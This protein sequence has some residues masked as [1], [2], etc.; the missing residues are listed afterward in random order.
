MKKYSVV[1]TIMLVVVMVFVL[2]GCNNNKSGSGT[3]TGAGD[4]GLATEEGAGAANNVIAGSEFVVAWIH[5]SM[6]YESAAQAR[7]AAVEYIERHEIEWTFEE[8]DCEGD[9]AKVTSAIEDAVAKGVNAIM[10]DFCDLHAATNAIEL[11]NQSGI[12]VFSVD[13]GYYVPGIVADVTTNNA[14]GAS[15]VGMFMINQLGG[16]GKVCLVDTKNHS[17]VRMRVD[18]FRSI[19]GQHAGMEILND[20]NVDPLRI[21]ESVQDNM[22]ALVTRYGLDGID[23]VL[24]GWDEA[25]MAVANVIRSAGGSRSDIIVSGYDGH[26]DVVVDDMADPTYPVIATIAQNFPAYGT[27][28]IDLIQ[29]VVLNG[30]DELEAIGGLRTIYVRSSLVT[31]NNVDSVPERPASTA[32]TP[33]NDY[34]DYSNVTG[35]KYSWQ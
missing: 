6:G 28:P 20:F 21:M 34:G 33:D 7:A 32:M 15:R 30:E 35:Y 2:M 4:A 26:R 27:I 10:C 24:C 9:V 1:L 17:G 12:K 14:E 13:T 29:K 8:V 3:D 23:A 31:L 25:A 22:E 5:G 16:N 11:A 18:V 19:I